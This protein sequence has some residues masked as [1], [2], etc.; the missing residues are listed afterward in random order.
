MEIIVGGK[1]DYFDDGKI[2]ESR[3]SDCTIIEKIPFKDIDSDTL[4]QWKDE[5]IS[6]DWLYAKETDFFLKAI[7]EFPDDEPETV[8]FVRTTDWGWFSL[9]FWG[10]RLKEKSFWE[11]EKVARQMP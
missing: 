10:G 6:C 5:V 8:Y 4:S 2:R 11:K 1:Y 7:I 3:R 9:G